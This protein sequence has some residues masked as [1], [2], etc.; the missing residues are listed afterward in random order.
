[1]RSVLRIVAVVAALAV[2]LVVVGC[3]S[4]SNAEVSDVVKKVGG[5]Y[6]GMAAGAGHSTAR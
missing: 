3:S 1:M 5:A 4:P 6:D 2:V